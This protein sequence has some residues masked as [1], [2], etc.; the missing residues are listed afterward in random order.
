MFVPRHRQHGLRIQHHLL[1]IGHGHPIVGLGL[2]QFL[3]RHDPTLLKL[4]RA[5]QLAHGVALDVLR[6]SPRE[7]GSR[8]K[9]RWAT[10]PR[11]PSPTPIPT[12]SAH[13]VDG[14]PVFRRIDVDQHVAHVHHVAQV[15]IDLDD[16]AVDFGRDQHF[17][18]TAEGADDVHRTLNGAER[19][20]RHRHRDG[21][22]V[23][24]ARWGP[25]LWPLR[26]GRCGRRGLSPP[27]YRG[28][29]PPRP[30]RR[31]SSSLFS[32]RSFNA[33]CDVARARHRSACRSG[34]MSRISCA[35]SRGD[36]R[37]PAK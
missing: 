21:R 11:P 18:L 28:P 36:C 37:R 24:L 4:P 17:F 23:P 22:A 1:H 3:L 35:C 14:Q 34:A 7:A 19:H 25:A 16:T 10:P 32:T 33:P 20:R 15:M 31:K 9:G 8:R 26:A 30:R 12:P 2:L 5:G 6:G 27:R 13:F 29:R